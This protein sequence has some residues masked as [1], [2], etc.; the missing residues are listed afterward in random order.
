[1][2]AH[3]YEPPPRPS[4]RD[5][6]IPSDVEAIV[7]RALA[8][9]PGARF[10]TMLDLVN[11]L[12]TSWRA[13]ASGSMPALF[14]LPVAATA[15][16]TP[17]PTRTLE[18]AATQVEP[19]ARTP[20]RPPRR[21]GI[22]LALGLAIALGA[23]AGLY[24]ARDRG[25]SS[26]V[27][28]EQAMPVGPP[29]VT[30]AAPS[31]PPASAPADAAA[32]PSDNEPDKRVAEEDQ[33]PPATQVQMTVTSLPPGAEVYR[34]SDGVRIGRTPFHRGFE[35][36]DGE[37]ELIVKLAGYR[38]ARVVMSTA[39]DS[40]EAV[41]LVRASTTT[42]VTRPPRERDERDRGA[43]PPNPS[44]GSAATVLDPYKDL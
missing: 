26:R 10:P 18:E 21:R 3:L 23:A 30:E 12:E 32:G 34:A 15:G 31:V 16:V 1:V 25:P 2:A 38:D 8:K 28:S 7:L 19:S 6:R 9:E 4:Q 35:R 5:G 22:R 27:A 11:A 39:T 41:K 17:T 20:E 33:A 36:T 24:L 43:P 40:T 29:L 14:S 37:L 44:T 13:T 42:K